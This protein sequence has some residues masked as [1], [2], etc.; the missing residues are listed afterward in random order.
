LCHEFDTSSVERTNDSRDGE[1][2]RRFMAS[3][4]REEEMKRRKRFAIRLVALG[5]AVTALAAPTAQAGP[6]GITG[7]ELRAIHESAVTTDGGIL[8]PDDR[9]SHG[10]RWEPQPVMSPEDLVVQRTTPGPTYS[11][12]SADDGSGFDLGTTTLTGIVLLF[13]AGG[14]GFVVLRQSRKGRLASA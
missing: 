10:S 14:A 13:A 11:P 1:P 5:F 3:T 8:A 12:T 6:D 9:M 2:Y 7:P 4:R